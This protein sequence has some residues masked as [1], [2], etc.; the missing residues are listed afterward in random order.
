MGLA[1]PEVSGKV[2]PWSKGNFAP[3]PFQIPSTSRPLYVIA[4]IRAG[5]VEQGFLENGG[6]LRREVLEV[7][8]KWVHSPRW[9]PLKTLL[10]LGHCKS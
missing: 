2:R 9:K 6:N 3:E 8:A 5:C 1:F 10:A 4:R 7:R